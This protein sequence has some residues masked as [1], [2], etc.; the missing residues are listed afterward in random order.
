MWSGQYEYLKRATAQLKIVIPV[1]LLIIFVLLYRNFRSI[2]E[3]MI[4]MLSLPFAL[5]GGLWL[6]WT[7]TIGM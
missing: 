4:V 5:V 6:I 1:T 7:P 3:T 2:T